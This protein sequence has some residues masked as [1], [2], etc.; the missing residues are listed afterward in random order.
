MTEDEAKELI[1]YAD[2]IYLK[3]GAQSEV[4]G[5]N[6]KTID[7]I[8]YEASRHNIQLIPCPVDT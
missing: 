3:F 6:S 5:L 4:H 1:N 2:S 8:K 7:D